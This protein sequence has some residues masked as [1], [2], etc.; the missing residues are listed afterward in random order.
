MSL[1]GRSV[2][3]FEF[4]SNIQRTC[5]LTRKQLTA[6]DFEVPVLYYTAK[7]HTIRI[8]DILFLVTL[9]LYS[10]VEYFD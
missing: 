1:S 6:V 4:P 10:V 3:T 8:V 2:P 7:G 5:T 9:T